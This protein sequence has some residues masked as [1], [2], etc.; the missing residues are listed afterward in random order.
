MGIYTTVNI[1]TRTLKICANE[2]GVRKICKNTEK[3]KGKNF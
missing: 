3:L 1:I 2:M